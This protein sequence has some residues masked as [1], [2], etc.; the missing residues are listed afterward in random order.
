MKE[1]DFKL[2]QEEVQETVNAL[3]TRP[4]NQVYGIISKIQSQYQSQTETE[5][6]GDS[7][8]EVLNESEHTK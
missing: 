7:K 2:T 6:T 1:L 3:S 4:F 5:S 8:E